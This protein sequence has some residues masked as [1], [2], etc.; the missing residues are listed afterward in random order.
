MVAIGLGIIIAICAVIFLGVSNANIYFPVLAAT[1]Y[2][3]IAF[4]LLN[5]VVGLVFKFTGNY[6]AARVHL[7]IGVGLTACLLIWW[8]YNVFVTP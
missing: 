3:V 7:I 8:A 2:T 4:P 5:I 6:E 1:A